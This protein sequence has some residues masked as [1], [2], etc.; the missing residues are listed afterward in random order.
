MSQFASSSAAWIPPRFVDALHGQQC[1]DEEA[2]A[3]RRRHAAGRGV[4]AGD[5]SHF[6]KIGHHVA[7]GRR[8]Q[9]EPGDARKLAR[10]NRLAVRDVAFDQSFQQCLC[11]LVQL[12]DEAI[13]MS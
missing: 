5:E 6:F 12:H 10:T 8:R 4:R 13:V 2:V 9:V 3:A 1:I 7:D 11:A